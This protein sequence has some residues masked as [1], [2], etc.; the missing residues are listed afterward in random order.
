MPTT[1][2]SFLQVLVRVVLCVCRTPVEQG[3]VCSQHLVIRTDGEGSRRSVERLLDA[4]GRGEGAG[5]REC[6]EHGASAGS[7]HPAVLVRRTPNATP[8]V[9][10]PP[11]S[12]ALDS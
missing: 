2:A 11:L 3:R 5:E 12:P 8:A 9:S 4:S 6:G 10:I 7:L 1:D